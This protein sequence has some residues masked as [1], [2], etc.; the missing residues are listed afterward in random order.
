MLSP[1]RVSE[2]V[3]FLEFISQKEHNRHL[4]K[5]ANK[6]AEGAFEKVWNNTEDD[7]YD[8]L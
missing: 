5:S 7:I 4:L 8:R 1:E 2:V 6:M 3:D